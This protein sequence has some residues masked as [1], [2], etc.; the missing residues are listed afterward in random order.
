MS[1]EEE[2]PKTEEA[3]PED[4]SLL[5]IGLAGAIFLFLMSGLCVLYLLLGDDSSPQQAPMPFTNPNTPI[6]VVM[7]HKYA[8]VNPHNNLTLPPVIPR[9]PE[10]FGN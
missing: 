3:P 8:N 10:Y 9:K 5:F 7:K 4:D 1:S 6:Y 2:T